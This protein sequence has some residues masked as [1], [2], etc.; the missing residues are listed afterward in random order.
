MTS[1]GIPTYTAFAGAAAPPPTLE[2]CDREPIHIPGFIQPHGALIAFD[3]QGSV[4]YASVNVSALLGFD[5]TPGQALAPDAL[6]DKTAVLDLIRQVIATSAAE[7]EVAPIALEALIQGRTWDVVVHSHDQVTVCE[8]ESRDATDDEVAS[9]AHKAYRSMDGMKRQRSVQR[10]LETTVHEIRTLT[11]FDRVMAYRFRHDDS[12]DVVAESRREDLDP[13]VGRR[14]PASDIPAQARRLYTL[15]T[16]RLIADVDYQPVPVLGATGD[17]LPLDMSHCLLRSVSPIHVEYLHNMGVGASMS[18]SIVVAGRLWGMFACHHMSP[19]QVPFSIRMATD[20]MAQLLASTVLSLEAQGRETAV[21]SAARLGNEVTRRIAL[22]EDV[23]DV[24]NAEADSLQQALASDVVLVAMD[25]QATA[26]GEVDADWIEPLLGWLQTQPGAQVHVR[27]AAELPQRP[28]GGTLRHCG[29]LA[30]RFDAL[31]QGWLIAL[32]KEQIETIRWGGRPEKDVQPGP[33]GPRLTPRGSF[34]E[35]RETVRETAEPWNETQLDIAGQL[36]D[37]VSRAHAQRVIELDSLR[38]RLWAVLGHDLRDPLQSLT[39]AASVLGRDAAGQDAQVGRMG[40]VIKKSTARMQRLMSD[41]LDIS[42]VQNGLGLDIHL[43]ETDLVKLIGDLMEQ[44]RV[45][46]PD[47]Q[48]QLDLPATLPARVDAG[49]VMQMM[50]NLLSN[51]RHHGSKG[52]MVTVKA[53]SAGDAAH[54]AV[55]NQ[56]APIP[57]ELVPTLFDPLKRPSLG[58]ERNRSGMGLGLYIAERIA[59]AHNG[60]IRYV[61][62]DGTVTFEVSFPQGVSVPPA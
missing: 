46:N 14:Y 37:A 13:Y 49:R 20:V 36:L 19:R 6:A 30:L 45:A 43:Q 1:P 42:R 54:V 28:G 18:V 58:N 34:E 8:F 60:H 31:R 25:G 40:A 48:L 57:P 56:A 3:S 44:T 9:F 39:M 2:T 24:L 51:A 38:S 27:T 4:R 7:D 23:L 59:S 5:A 52:G 10:L 22:G 32:R 33:L 35:W 17:T 62:G 26:H 41:V 21:A 16:L 50:S 53:W 55:T 15:N 61:P 29:V 12:G 47:M 11:G